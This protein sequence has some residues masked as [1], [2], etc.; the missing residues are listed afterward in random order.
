MGSPED[1][2]PA[3]E[4]EGTQDFA[5]PQSAGGEAPIETRLDKICLNEPTA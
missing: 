3:P 1:G 5:S 2:G 4:N